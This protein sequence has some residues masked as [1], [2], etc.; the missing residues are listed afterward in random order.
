MSQQENITSVLMGGLGNY[1]FQI[2]AAYSYGKKYNKNLIFDHR[3]ASGPHRKV[4]EYEKNILNQINLRS[5]STGF[6]IYNEPGFHHQEIPFFEGNLSLHGYFQSEKY[7]ME[8]RDEIR[9]LFTS[10][11]ISPDQDLES[12]ILGNMSCSLH[13]RRGD[14]LKF[15]SHHPTQTIDY[16]KKA[17]STIPQGCVFIVFSDDIEWCRNN[18]ESVDAQFVF[19]EGYNDYEDIALMRMCNHNIISNSTFSWWGAWLNDDPD[20]IV[21]APKN[22]FGPAYSNLITEDIF[23]EGWTII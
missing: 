4:T 16:F 22:W 12:A 21:I 14:F 7:F 3:V 8:Y 13:V 10:Y 1:L 20:K 6:N 9:K 2:A 17:I 18:F 19:V 5:D 11:K 15:P 23:C